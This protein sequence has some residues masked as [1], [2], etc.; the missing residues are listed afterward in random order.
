MRT[1]TLLFLMLLVF[2]SVG[3]TKLPDRNLEL[4]D[5]LPPAPT[6]CAPGERL[7]KIRNNCSST[8]IW[9]GAAGNNTAKA[10]A[11]GTGPE[12]SCASNKDCPGVNQFCNPGNPSKFNTYCIVDTDCAQGQYCSNTGTAGVLGSPSSCTSNSDC[13]LNTTCKANKCTF[14]Q[15]AINQCY[16]VPVPL[17]SPIPSNAQSCR[18]P[19]D[20]SDSSTFC[21]APDGNAAG[22]CMPV[23]QNGNNWPLSAQTSTAVCVP[24]PWAGRFWARTNCAADPSGQFFC[25]VGQCLGQDGKFDRNCA[26][27]G[28]NAP[29]VAEMFFPTF[30]GSSNDFYDISMV[31][32][33]TIA[34]QLAPLSSTYDMT[35][36]NARDAGA[37]PTTQTCQQLHQSP[38]WVC[39]T[40][41]NKCVNIYQ[42]ASPGCVSNCNSYGYGALLPSN[43]CTWSGDLAVPKSTCPVELQMLNSGGTYVGCQSPKD[44][45]T[46][47]SPDPVLS[48]STNTPLFG[49][50]GTYAQ[51]CYYNG[52]NNTCCGCPTWAPEC[53]DP[54]SG[55]NATWQ[56]V[57]APYYQ[58][59]KNLCPTAYTFPFDDKTSTF[60]CIAKTA[61]TN[62]DYTLTFCPN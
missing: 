23:P 15:C 43:T 35:N 29:T 44:A 39:D 34:I 5:A 10:S 7:I 41:Q 38:D 19:R 8:K 51:P 60:T 25:D 21:Y 40:T 52:G 53:A 30:D 6:S 45:C 55:N 18:S 16:F 31:D 9:V 22:F 58:V 26:L 62:V 20:C 37:C 54:D 1:K 32:G 42:C 14:Y 46:A 50:T 27:S 33:A 28:V 56:S 47:A 13:P 11:T 57:A 24:T 48:C 17:D 61:E 49:C 4:G 12:T 36:P 2:A 59:F 3:C